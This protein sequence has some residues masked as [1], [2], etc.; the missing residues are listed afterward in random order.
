MN[1]LVRYSAFAIVAVVGVLLVFLFP[2]HAGALSVTHGPATAFRARAAAR[3]LFAAIATASLMAL[4]RGIRL[5]HPA[6]QGALALAPEAAP[7]LLRC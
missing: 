7:F 6:H 4:L 1:K 2:A 5:T 3:A